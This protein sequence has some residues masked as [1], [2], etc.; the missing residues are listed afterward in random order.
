MSVRSRLLA[1]VAAVTTIAGAAVAVRA[2]AA[3]AGPAPPVPWCADAA[4]TF[5][6]V[7]SAT[8]NGASLY[9]DPE[10][11][12]QA[13]T[14][15]VPGDPSRYLSFTAQRHGGY[16]LGAAA[17]SDVWVVH[18][19]MGA[20]FVPRVAA[21]HARDVRVSRN[22]DP[23]TG[24]YAITVRG[25]PVTVTQG[26]DQSVWPWACP[27][28]AEGEFVG[29]FDAQITDYAVWS[30]IPSRNAMYGMDYFT[31]MDA[32]SVPPEVRRDP[33]TGADQLLI[34]MANSHFR[35]DGETVV[36]GRSELRIPNAFLRIGYG[37][38]D[39]ATMTGTSLIAE[40]S[41]TPSTAGTSAIWQEPGADAMRVS[42]DGVTF[43]VRT[44][45]VRR[46]II[47][48]T[49]P[50]GPHATRT[51]VHRGRVAF[52]ASRPRGAR[53]TGYRARCT[54]ATGR[55][56]RYGTGSRSPVVVTGLLA[57]RAY[58]CQARALSKAGPSAWSDR[59]FMVKAPPVLDAP[60]A[61]YRPS[62]THNRA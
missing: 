59:T 55:D 29:Y 3:S 42:L 39:P 14:Y 9:Q 4:T 8:R 32:T 15:T 40:I 21:G 48:P 23:V 41:G 51:A 27:S 7:V 37:V 45:K 58:W 50:T 28:V 11:S 56:I 24:R 18:L 2:P 43:S 1:G 6:C 13:L 5:P 34:R 57:G 12:V 16:E 52:T 61:F 62:R 20:G 35:T 10:W 26:C 44:L 38:P 19:D 22:H 17:L 46:G 49:R 54:A 60:G 47:T 30:D 53:V 25:S 31:N 33:L 36:L